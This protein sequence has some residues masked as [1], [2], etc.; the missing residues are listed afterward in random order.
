MNT[1][2]VLGV[3]FKIVYANLE[4]EGVYGD[5]DPLSQIIR[6]D[7]TIPLDHQHKVLA[8]ELTHAALR[9]S[10]LNELVGDKVEEAIC[11]LMETTYKVYEDII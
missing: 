8:H 2:Y 1:I 9:I 5:C 11:V 6:I 4:K 7:N 10:G 3:P